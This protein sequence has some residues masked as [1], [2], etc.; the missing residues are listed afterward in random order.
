MSIIAGMTAA[1]ASLELTTK[2]MDLLNRPEIDVVDVRAKVHEMLIHLVNAQVALGEAHVEIADLRHRLDERD[3]LKALDSDM[4]FQINGGFYVKKSEA[5]KGL[6]PYCP[7]CW[8]K[9]HNTVPLETS[10][11]PG[12]FKCSVHSTVYETNECRNRAR[13]ASGGSRLPRSGGS[14]SWMG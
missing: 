13:S 5:A 14:S 3:T 8:Q 12:W 2:L 11:T 4:D 1:K 10:K 6:I 9:D 7:I